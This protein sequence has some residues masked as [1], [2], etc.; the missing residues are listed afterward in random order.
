MLSGKLPISV[1]VGNTPVDRWPKTGDVIEV[2]GI[3][4]MSFLSISPHTDYSNIAGIEIIPGDEH[5]IKTISQRP[6]W[7]PARFTLVA[8]VLLILLLGTLIWNR[9]LKRLADRRGRA[10]FRERIAHATAELRVAERT[11][12][13]IELHDSIAQSLTGVAFHVTAADKALKSGKETAMRHIGTATKILQHSR[14]DLRRCIWD[15]RNDALELDDFS[16]AIRRTVMPVL[17]DAEADIDFHI[18]RK[19]MS[20][21]T[22][23][24]ILSVIRELTSNSVRH[25][26]SRNV[27]VRGKTENGCLIFSVQDNVIRALID[28]V[29]HIEVVLVFGLPVEQVADIFPVDQVAALAENEVSVSFSLR[30]FGI[31]KNV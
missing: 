2:T 16:E 7:T 22:A 15:L 17:D 10:L 1:Y 28:A 13:A 25:G 20:D 4:N 21:S 6:W 8:T 5:G 12:L 24:T 9:A 11:R 3:C 26:K 27:F 14:V 19:R 18:P 31:A 30:F 29:Q 23:H